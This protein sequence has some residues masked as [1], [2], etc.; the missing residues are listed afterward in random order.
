MKKYELRH[1][2]GFKDNPI[3]RFPNI[4]L[5]NQNRNKS[6]VFTPT[7]FDIQAVN[8]IYGGR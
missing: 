1:T 4:S 3:A 5:M 7:D 2:M 8:I 6:E